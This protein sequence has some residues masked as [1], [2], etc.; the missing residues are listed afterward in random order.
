MFVADVLG[1]MVFPSCLWF[2]SAVDGTAFEVIV[3]GVTFA[4]CHWVNRPQVPR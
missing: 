2:I 3:F 1:Q 4:I